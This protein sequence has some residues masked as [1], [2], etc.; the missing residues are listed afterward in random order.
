MRVDPSQLAPRLRAVLEEDAAAEVVIKAEED[1][2]HEIE[3]AGGRL[4]TIDHPADE[5]GVES[6]RYWATR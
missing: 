5:D 2:R 6:S 1:V 4:V 3:R